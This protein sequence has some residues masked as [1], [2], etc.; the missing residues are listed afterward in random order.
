MER[1]FLRNKWL[2]DSYLKIVKAVEQDQFL[3]EEERPLLEAVS[4]KLMKTHL[5][6]KTY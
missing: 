5:T 6:E 2:C 3:E 4:R 1:V